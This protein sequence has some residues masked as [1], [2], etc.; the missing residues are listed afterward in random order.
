MFAVQGETGIV[1]PVH[2]CLRLVSL[3]DDTDGLV[4]PAMRLAQV[5]LLYMTPVKV[6]SHSIHPEPVLIST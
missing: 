6:T 2:H 3:S 1:G 4:L 5:L